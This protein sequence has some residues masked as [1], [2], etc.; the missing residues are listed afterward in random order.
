MDEQSI[1]GLQPLIDWAVAALALAGQSRSG[2]LHVVKAFSG[3]A[4]VGVVDG[5][6][7]GVEA[8]EASSAAAA[9]LE[10]HA[11]EPVD[12]LMRRCHEKLMGTRGAAM[13]LAS[14]RA[15]DHTMSWLGVGNVEGVLM[16]G[17]GQETAKNEGIVQRGGIVG[18]NLPPLRV[19]VVPVS[20][21]DTLILATDG[22]RPGFAKVL[23]PGEPIQRS[24]DRILDRCGRDSDD[25]L[26]LV[27]RVTGG[28]Q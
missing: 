24:A 19:S 5:L 8:S 1:R 21:G 10:G 13:T 22:I 25:A 26:V 7:H 20:A 15:T 2:D 11:C 9:V 17:S 23:T 6:G 28:C 27:V 3:G 4:L 18:L 16:R 12:S 14:I